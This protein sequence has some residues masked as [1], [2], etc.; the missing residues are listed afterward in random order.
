MTSLRAVLCLSVYQVSPAQ[1]HLVP[2]AMVC[3][4]V[5]F[6]PDPSPDK[7]GVTRVSSL[8]IHSLAITDVTVSLRGV[9]AVSLNVRVMLASAGLRLFW[10]GCGGVTRA[11]TVV[12]DWEHHTH[13]SRS[14]TCP[15]T[16]G[17]RGWHK[18]TP[19]RD[20]RRARSQAASQRSC[21][22]RTPTATATRLSH[23]RR[24]QTNS[25]YFPPSFP[26]V[27]QLWCQ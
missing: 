23:S 25:Q 19:P 27:P 16:L 10:C 22:C 15:S 20:T 9:S 18:L 26:R 21:A 5:T 8:V 2:G 3:L 12:P 13:A 6:S 17:R 24:H 14:L 1:C 7:A 11:G 4:Q